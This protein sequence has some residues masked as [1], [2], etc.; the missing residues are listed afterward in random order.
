MASHV[1]LT[2]DDEIITGINVT[3]LVDVVLV[4]L[5]IFMVTA[6]SIVGPSIEVDLPKAA[7][8][9]ETTPSTV[10][11]V[12]SADGAVYLNGE[13]SDEA[14]VLQKVRAEVAKT[15][16]LQVVIAADRSTTHG[17]VV[18]F[19]DAV[20]A[21]GVTRFALSTEPIDSES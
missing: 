20:K 19:V 18:G 10:S 21:A 7:T 2:D 15:P 6:S 4:L 9:T 3:P 11:V 8:A 12:L 1:S 14:L 5:I 16:E 13:A 17:R